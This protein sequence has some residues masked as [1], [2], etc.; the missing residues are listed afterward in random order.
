MLTPRFSLD[1]DMLLSSPQC[2]GPGMYN[3]TTTTNVQGTFDLS[4]RRKTIPS[5][6]SGVYHIAKLCTMFN[7]ENYEKCLQRSMFKAPLTCQLGADHT[8][9]RQGDIYKQPHYA[10]SP[11]SHKNTVC[12]HKC[13]N[14]HIHKQ[15]RRLRQGGN[16]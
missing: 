4:V 7:T 9:L 8:W 12:T 5:S 6:G 10:N 13:T 2:R 16:L 1:S 3:Y 15:T 14:T 11:L